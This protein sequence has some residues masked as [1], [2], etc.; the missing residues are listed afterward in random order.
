MPTEESLKKAQSRPKLEKSKT[1]KAFQ[2]S[3]KLTMD[4]MKQQAKVQ[5]SATQ[6][7]GDEME[8]MIDM[9]VE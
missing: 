3:K 7:Q 6:G 2:A 9:F 4:A 8:M 1:L 5:R